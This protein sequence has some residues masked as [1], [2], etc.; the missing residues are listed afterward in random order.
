MRRSVAELTGPASSL[1]G[2][3]SR[4]YNW[5]LFPEAALMERRRCRKSLPIRL[6][7]PAP[8]CF[9]KA[10]SRK[11]KRLVLILF[12][13]ARDARERFAK[14]NSGDPRGRPAASAIPGGVCNPRRR[15]RARLG[16]IRRLA[17]F[18]RRRGYEKGPVPTP[19]GVKGVC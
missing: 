12:C 17:R 10:E 16:A 4:T 5:E 6:I 8:S 11:L 7:R 13:L 1:D 2:N 19:S 14:R 9:L 3:V 15:V 18:E